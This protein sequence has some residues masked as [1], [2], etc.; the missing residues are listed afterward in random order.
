VDPVDLKLIEVC[1]MIV[2]SIKNFTPL[3][4]FS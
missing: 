2:D 4:A 3:P 1:K